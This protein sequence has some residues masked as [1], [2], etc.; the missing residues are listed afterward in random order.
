MIT[1][2]NASFNHNHRLIITRI[3]LHVMF[4]TQSCD[5]KCILIF[6][7]FLRIFTLTFF[8]YPLFLNANIYF[9]TSR[10]YNS[11]QIQTQFVQPHIK[12]MLLGEHMILRWYWINFN[13]IF[14]LYLWFLLSVKWKLRI[15][16]NTST[17]QFN[18]YSIR[19][20]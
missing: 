18:K 1:T 13:N 15:I 4:N 16:R 12:N 6:E 9:C 20:K 2:F 7:P 19:E 8:L 11:F 17:G 10:N 3:V 14:C 5:W